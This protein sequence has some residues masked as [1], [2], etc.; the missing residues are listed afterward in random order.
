MTNQEIREAAGRAAAWIIDDPPDPEMVISREQVLDE[1][2][3]PRLP[4]VMTQKQAKER[5]FLELS[6]FEEWRRLISTATGRYPKTVRGEGFRLLASGEV[7][8]EVTADAFRKANLALLKA[9][10]IVSNVRDADLTI[11][12]KRRKLD[13]QARMGWARQALKAAERASLSKPLEVAQPRPLNQSIPT[14]NPNTN[15]QK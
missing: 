7:S 5:A 8:P 3:V 13:D 9:S 6:F 12:E 2:G 1:G 11:E 15:P 14:I 10:Y 4:E